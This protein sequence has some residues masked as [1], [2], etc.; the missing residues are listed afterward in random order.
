MT[1]HRKKHAHILGYFL[2]IS[3][4]SIFA[5]N[6]FQVAQKLGDWNQTNI[7]WDVL[8]DTIPVHIITI[9]LGLIAFNLRKG[10]EAGHPKAVLFWTILCVFLV[11]DSIYTLTVKF[12]ALILLKAIF[13]A[14][15]TAYAFS[16]VIK[17]PSN[18]KISD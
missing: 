12:H 5:Y 7:I 18:D 9:F 10:L 8:G 14:Y 4:V 6:Y 15:L 17:G 16:K 2:I 3:T 11:G 1:D 13:F